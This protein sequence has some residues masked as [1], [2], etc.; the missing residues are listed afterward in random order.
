MLVLHPLALHP[1]YET[2]PSPPSPILC[3]FIAQSVKTELKGRSRVVNLEMF[4]M[5]SHEL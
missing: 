2:A 5:S 4:E 1:Q 3:V